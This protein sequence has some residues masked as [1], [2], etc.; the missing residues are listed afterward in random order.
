VLRNAALL[1]LTLAACACL[2]TAASAQER[3]RLQALFD[4][5][6]YTESHFTL[7]FDMLLIGSIERDRALG[8]PQS[9]W[10]FSPMLG[11]VWRD[12][13]GHPSLAR[14]RRAA[15]SVDQVYGSLP[16]DEWRRLVKQ[17]VNDR[18][19]AYFGVMTTFFLLPGVDIGVMWDFADHHGVGSSL[20]A[21]VAVGWFPLKYVGVSH[22][23]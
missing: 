22:S 18:F 1:L 21:G 17:E 23:F 6:Q 7:G 4:D 8:Y 9:A 19:F 12:Y 13:S 3:S 5:L 15:E 20:S 11:V 10:G 14:I 2:C 16:E